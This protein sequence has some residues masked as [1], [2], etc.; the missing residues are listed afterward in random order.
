MIEAPKGK[1]KTVLLGHNPLLPDEVAPHIFL[2]FFALAIQLVA[3]A[4]SGVGF[5]LNENKFW[6]IGFVLW[7]LWFFIMLI[8][9]NPNTDI[10]LKNHLEGVKR[11]AS[12]VIV[13]FILIG[14]AELATAVFVAPYLA[15]FCIDV[16]L[17]PYW[18]LRHPYKVYGFCGTIYVPFSLTAYKNRQINRFQNLSYGFSASCYHG[19]NS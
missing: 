6:L 8:I 18:S 4:I 9:V 2:M 12:I 19:N 7:V 13:I 3:S 15:P 16:S 11:V 17:I 10:I 14:V 1:Q 5:S